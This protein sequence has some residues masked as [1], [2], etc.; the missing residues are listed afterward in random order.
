MYGWCCLY[1]QSW[2]CA[3][4]LFQASRR[5]NV[6]PGPV[7]ESK[8]HNVHEDLAAVSESEAREPGGSNPPSSIQ[9]ASCV[10]ATDTAL[11][12]RPEM[13][14]M[15]PAPA[16]GH[17]T[18]GT[19]AKLHD[20][21]ASHILNFPSAASQICPNDDD[22][23]SGAS[24]LRASDA[25]QQGRFE[26]EVLQPNMGVDTL[27]TLARMPT[28]DMS[29]VAAMDA[30]HTNAFTQDGPGSDTKAAKNHV[31]PAVTETLP[32]M[33]LNTVSSLERMATPDMS[34]AKLMEA[35]DTQRMEDRFGPR[36]AAQASEQQ[37]RVD[38]SHRHASH[39]RDHPA[40]EGDACAPART[41]SGVPN[42]SA[43]G[44]AS[45]SSGHASSRADDDTPSCPG[46][47]CRHVL[48]YKSSAGVALI[49]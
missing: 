49:T 20:R 26:A 13:S 1:L 31:D 21:S 44:T 18:E 15:S 22:N 9:E 2:I 28:P 38:G 7:S 25:T 17:I 6:F 42:A 4:A 47:D 37:D 16:D 8:E 33:G 5:L 34:T 41:H 3:G 12:L 45:S 35:L 30:L 24:Q 10:S 27:Q 36:P 14:P 11:H 23:A 46:T 19:S 48:A 43:K 29:T 32:A 39:F 40:D